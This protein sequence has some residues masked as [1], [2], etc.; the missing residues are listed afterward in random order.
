MSRKR[1]LTDDQCRNLA[2]WYSTRMSMEAKA[3]ELGI[4]VSAL[5]DAINRG[6][7]LNVPRGTDQ[8]TQ[9]EVIESAA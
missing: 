5:Y 7:L 1:A 4:S 8:T 9:S 2:T 3:K 6:I